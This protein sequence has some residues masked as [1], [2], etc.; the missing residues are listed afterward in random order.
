ME[1]IKMTITKGQEQIDVEITADGTVIFKTGSHHGPQHEA[2]ETAIRTI[3]TAC[4]GPVTRKKRTDVN[5][6]HHHHHHKA[7][8]NQ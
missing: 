8:H 5:T 7:T 3:L 4:G 1:R 2:V 6:T